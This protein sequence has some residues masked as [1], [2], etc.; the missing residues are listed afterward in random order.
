MRGFSTRDDARWTQ[1][2]IYAH[3]S[4]RIRKYVPA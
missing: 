2:H 3:L 4:T 1:K